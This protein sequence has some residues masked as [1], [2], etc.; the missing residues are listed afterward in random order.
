MGCDF[1]VLGGAERGERWIVVCGSDLVSRF[2]RSPLALLVF[3]TPS[4]SLR[5]AGPASARDGQVT[6]RARDA[7]VAPCPSPPRLHPLSF[8]PSP[9]IPCYL[10][11]R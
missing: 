9:F 2:P 1:W 4:S 10:G 6:V 8:S 7:S 3:P 11:P 5:P